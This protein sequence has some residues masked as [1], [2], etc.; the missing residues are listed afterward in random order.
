MW[1]AASGLKSENCW[2]EPDS[3][4]F[5]V[6]GLNYLRDRKKVSAGEPFADLIA[7][8]WLVDYQRI[9]NVCSR[10]TGRDVHSP[11]S[12]H[13]SIH[14]S[15]HWSISPFI[16]PLIGPFIGPFIGPLVHS[17][18]HWSNHWSTHWSIIPFIGL[19]TPGSEAAAALVS[20]VSLS[21]H[22]P[23]PPINCLGS[24]PTHQMSGPRQPVETK[25]L[26][27]SLNYS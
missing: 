25:F 11:H 27:H 8:D 13:W 22:P 4:Y 18:V 5:R 6:R 16:S 9:D 24:P 7:T 26:I 19:L 14:W 1:P 17:L 10:P 3:N 20:S 21:P 2:C 23:H 15:T 12:V